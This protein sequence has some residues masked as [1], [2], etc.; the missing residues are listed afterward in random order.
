MYEFISGEIIEISPSFAIIETSGS[1]YFINI[2]LLTYEIL[3][4]KKTAKIFIPQILREDTNSLFG[5]AEKSEREIFRQL[6]SVSGSGANTARLMLSSLKPSEI[7]R[8]I[9][10]GDVTT[11]KSVKGIG[12]KTA[13]RVIVDLK[14]KVGKIET[15]DNLPFASANPV[16]EEAISARETLG[17]NK[18]TA[19]KAIQNIIILN[20]SVTVE[21]LVNTGLQ[22]MSK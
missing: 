16:L 5:F 8:A 11:L 14:D 4:T 1:G 20:S 9:L 3:N 21:E 10:E 6:I 12:L 15:D 17:L 7:A 18:N 2:S 13:Q 19:E 22:S